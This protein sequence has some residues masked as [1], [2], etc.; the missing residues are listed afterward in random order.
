MT[1]DPASP[2]QQATNRDEVDRALLSLA[3]LLGEAAAAEMRDET[4][5]HEAAADDPQDP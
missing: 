2:Q 4:P 5:T 3:H 1:R